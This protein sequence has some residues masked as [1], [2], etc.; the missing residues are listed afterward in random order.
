MT[1]LRNPQSTL[2]VEDDSP[3]TGGLAKGVWKDRP[4]TPLTKWERRWRGRRRRGSRHSRSASS[5]CVLRESRVGGFQFCGPCHLV[6]RTPVGR[7]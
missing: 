4:V 6:R 1:K 2:T 5:S 7:K 3:V